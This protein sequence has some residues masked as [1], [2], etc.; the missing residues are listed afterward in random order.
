MI[1]AAVLH[2]NDADGFGAAYAHWFWSNTNNSVAHYIPVQYGQPVPAI[3]EGVMELFI[4]DFSYDRET[5]EALAADYTLTIIDHHKTA[6]KELEGLDYAIFDMNK[7]GAVLAWDYFDVGGSAPPDLLLYV[8]DRD[9]WK[10][11]LPYSEEINLA[12]ASLPWEFEAWAD[13]NIDDLKAQG[14]AIKA[15]RDAQMKSTMKSVRMLEL[16]CDVGTFE[17]PVVNAS[18]N[19]SELGDEM[20]KAYPEAPFSASYC[21]RSDARSW[22]LRSIRDFDVSVVA[23]SCGGGGRKNTAGFSTELGWPTFVCTDFREG[24]EEGAKG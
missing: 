15:F 16:A 24:F 6:Q 4:L 10:W 2:H 19:V 21:D 18:N 13:A 1:K 7:S 20:C 11:E 5:C 9:L 22:S 8:Q 3:P 17:V 23:K 12:I 14:T